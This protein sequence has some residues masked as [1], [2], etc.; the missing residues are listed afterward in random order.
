MD[1]D[2]TASNAYDNVLV[3]SESRICNLQYV[4]L[5]KYVFVEICYELLKDTN[6]R[7]QVKI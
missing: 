1:P 7:S 5:W 2:Q 4:Y 3:S 6:R